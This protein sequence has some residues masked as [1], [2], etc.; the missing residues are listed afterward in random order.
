[1]KTADKLPYHMG[2]AGDLLKHGMLAVR[3][4]GGGEAVSLCGPVWGIA[5]LRKRRRVVRREKSRA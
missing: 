4:V 5:V 3:I 2:N 1:M